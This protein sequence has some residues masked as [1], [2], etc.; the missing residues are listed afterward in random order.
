MASLCKISIVG[1]LGRDAEQRFTPGGDAVVT[2]SV[3]T[4]EVRNN[5]GEREEHTQ[6][7]RVDFWG[8]RGERI[9]DYLTK[10]QRVYVD[11][12]LRVRD[13]EDRDGK[14]RYSLDVRADDVLLLGSRR[15]S[16][17]R[18]DRYEDRA[19]APA[20][21]PASTSAPSGGGGG[22]VDLADDDIPF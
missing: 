16:E 21:A 19:P 20:P 22:N 5:R 9:K 6:W 14:A 2:F 10:G 15:D 17:N 4:T 11:G 12:R 1:N 8:K 18:Q 3:A 13:Y 7:F